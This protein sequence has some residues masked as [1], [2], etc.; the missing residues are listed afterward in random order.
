MQSARIHFEAED[1]RVAVARLVLLV[2]WS[3]L[4]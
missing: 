3:I 1:G 4:V 2:D